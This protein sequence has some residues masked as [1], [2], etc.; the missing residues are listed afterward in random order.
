MQL[1]A[2]WQEASR[3]DV[4]RAFG[5][6]QRK[7]Q[8]LKREIEQWFLSDIKNIVQATIILHNTMVE[9]RIE[10][11]EFESDNFYEYDGNIDSNIGINEEGSDIDED[12][13]VKEVAELEANY[14]MEQLYY[15]GA[16]VNVA[17]QQHDNLQKWFSHH[18]QVALRHWRASQMTMDYLGEWHTHPESNPSPSLLDMSEWKKICKVQ[19]RPMVFAILGWSGDIW[20]GLSSGEVVSQCVVAEC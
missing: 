1:F 6:I 11:D 5:V 10:N 15:K 19:K 7:F 13:V 8:I 20:L 3:K 14:R 17:A 9:H 18:Q 2:S 4:E 12:N 16:A